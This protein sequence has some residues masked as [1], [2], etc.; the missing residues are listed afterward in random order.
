MV[1]VMS[2][3]NQNR[4]I[5]PMPFFAI[6]NVRDVNESMKWY[7]EALGFYHIFSIPGPDNE[8]LLAHLRWAKYADVLLRRET[9]V[10]N[11]PKGKG[12]TLNF[13]VTDGSVDEIAERAR[14][15][16]DRIVSEPKNQPW[17]AR[18]FSVMDPDGFTLTFTQGP[19]E[20]DLGMDQVIARSKQPFP[21]KTPE[22]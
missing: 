21:S 13:N 4:D 17:N 7:Q 19:V 10:E 2:I 22:T 16:G 20:K 14:R 9:K 12:L 5:Y 11:F 8:P 3:E 18:D 1:K 6:L 15:F